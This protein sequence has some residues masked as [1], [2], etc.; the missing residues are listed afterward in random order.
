M[1]KKRVIAQ[2]CR[3]RARGDVARKNIYPQ[4]TQINTDYWFLPVGPRMRTI[5]FLLICVNL[6]NLWINILFFFCAPGEQ[7]KALRRLGVAIDF[8]L[9]DLIFFRN[10]P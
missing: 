1:L 7:E 3:A 6:C 2:L 9:E 5:R 4:I 10:T 8:C